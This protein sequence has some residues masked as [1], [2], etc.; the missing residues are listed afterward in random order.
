CRDVEPGSPWRGPRVS[1]TP[2]GSLFIS[3]PVAPGV[4][5][6]HLLPILVAI[7]GVAILVWGL[8]RGRLPPAAGVAGLVLP[9]AAYGFGMLMVLEGSKDA[10]FCG[11][12]QLMTPIGESP[13]ATHRR[14]H[15]ANH[16]TR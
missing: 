15:A 11:S 7:P 10:R 3:P 9:I 12:C 6:T 4:D 8:V 2:V 5:W 16:L 13:R 1:S 14:S